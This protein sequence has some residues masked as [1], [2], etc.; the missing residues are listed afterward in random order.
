MPRSSIR[1]SISLAAEFRSRQDRRA[2]C[3]ADQLLLDD[4]GLV[5]LVVGANNPEF[6]FTDRR[7]GYDLFGQALLV[8]ADQGVRGPCD[9]RRAAVVGFE[10]DDLGGLPV[11]LELEQV[12]DAR[13]AP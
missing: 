7:G 9:R 10:I 1:R 13:A 6:A 12:G 5:V 3:S 4:V 2:A 11:V 8:V